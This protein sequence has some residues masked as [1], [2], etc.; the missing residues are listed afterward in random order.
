MTRRRRGVV[1]L[2]HF[3]AVAL[4]E[5]ELL[6]RQEIVREHPVKLPDFVEFLQLGRG[7]VAQVTHQF[8]HVS[9]VLLL[10][11]STVITAA[12]PRPGEGD[13]IRRAVV[14]QVVIDELGPVIRTMPTSA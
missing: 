12:C 11:V 8:T 4:L 7:V 2:G 1:S 5:D 9:P 6:L 13:L 3:R 10:H 14:E